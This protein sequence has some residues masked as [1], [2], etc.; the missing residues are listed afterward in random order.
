MRHEKLLQAAK[1]AADA[2]HSD[3]SVS[4]HETFRS[5]GDLRDHIEVLMDGVASS[6]PTDEEERGDGD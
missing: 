4:L 2:L 6:M 5:L 3:T 1:E